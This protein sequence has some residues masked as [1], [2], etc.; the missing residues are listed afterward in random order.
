MKT[1]CITLVSVLLIWLPAAIAAAEYH[2]KQDGTGDFTAIQQAIHAAVEGDE[3][4][5]HPGT[6]YEN[7]EFKGKN[8]VLRSTDPEDWAAVEAT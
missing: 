8:I 2:V 1:R 3:I 5:V 7:I 6:Y 4:I